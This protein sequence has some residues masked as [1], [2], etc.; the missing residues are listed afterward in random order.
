MTGVADVISKY[1]TSGKVS[2]RFEVDSNG[3]LV[4]D[5]AEA[6]VEV[7]VMEEVIEPAVNATASATPAAAAAAVDG[8]EVS[9]GRFGIESG[10][11]RL[12]FWNPMHRPCTVFGGG[13]RL[14]LCD[15]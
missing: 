14:A 11:V 1:N 13:W 4:L 5:R 3:L 8:K 10:T 12:A 6:A 15:C 7:E 2:L 9:A